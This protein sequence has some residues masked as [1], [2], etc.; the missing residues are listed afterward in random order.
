M[1]P[2]QILKTIS[3]G[4]SEALEFKTS[5]DREVI[6]T[7]T[8]FSN[9]GGGTVLV[10]VADN[11]EVRGIDLGKESLQDWLN[12]IKVSTIPSLFPDAEK[13]SLHGKTLVRL[14]IAE[15]PIK[16]VSCK[17]KYFRRSKN[18][19][20]QMSITEISDLHLK[21]FNASWDYYKDTQHT[22]DE[23]SLQKVTSFI[24]QAST[25]RAY[26]IDDAPLTVLTKYELL[27]GQQ[28]T[29]GCHL[30]FMDGESPLTNINAG[31]FASETLIKDNLTI[32]TDLFSEVDLL[33]EFIR[34]HIN[35]EYV[36]TGDAQ[37]KERWDY[38]LSALR[39][40]VI[41][42]VVHRDY[43]HAGDSIVKIFDDRIEFFNP[44]KLSP[45]MTIQNL[46]SGN[47]IS[48]IRNKQIALIFKEAGLMEKYGSGIKRILQAF[49]EYD[50]PMPLFEEYQHGFKV[51]VYKTPHKTPHKTP[52]KL[53]S[54]S[55]RILELV[56][57]E[58]DIS[59]KRVGERLGISFD[60]A[61]EYFAKLKKQ[62][63]LV[64][65]GGRKSGYWEVKK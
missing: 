48:C 24:A 52:Q 61:R 29:H 27:K 5:F 54:L 56:G 9:T 40:I 30:L 2:E 38:P 49:A 58:P 28:I 65:I 51:T 11:G 6:E 26:P 1:T 22:I 47:Y 16:P 42:M 32:C 41:N 19:N 17:G 4:E 60:T 12:R 63:R 25:L 23:I 45:E 50:L 7:L 59:Q 35:K 13:V 39:E 62:G 43:M 55:D 20:H 33:L 14:V 3:T 31:R 21:T 37:R 44:G 10:G 57:E 46:I 53:G 64:R 34:K 18:S 36:I 8:A 15:H